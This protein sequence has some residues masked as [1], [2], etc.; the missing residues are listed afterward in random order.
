VTAATTDP[1]AS[2]LGRY[3]GPDIPLGYVL[4]DSHDGLA[5]IYD[6]PAG[7]LRLSYQE[8]AERSIRLAG[9][10]QQAGLAAGDRVAVMLPKSPELMTALLAIWRAGAVHVPL[11]T[12]FGPDA[13]A[14]R[15]GHSGAR[16][17]ITDSVNRDKF[18]GL[19]ASG[20]DV[21]CLPGAGTPL[22]RGDRDLAAAI[23]HG[24]PGT[25]LRR[26]G[27][28]LLILLYTSGT[29]GQPKG[30]ELPVRALASIHSYMHYGL[31]VRPDDVFWNIADP[32]WGYGLWFAIIGPLLLGQAT[33]LRNMPFDAADVASAIAR[34]RVTNLTGAPT[35]YRSLRAAGMP[36]GFRE[37]SR[38][39][40]VSSAGEPLN[41][42]LLD[43]SARELGVPLHDHYGQTELGMPAGFA[44]H[45]SLHRNP[46]PGSMGFAAPGYRVVLL[47]EDGREA[48]PGTAGEI[49]IDTQS[50]PLYWFRGY[51]RDPERTKDRFRHGPRYYLT[52]DK[53][54]W[55]NAGLLHF[56]SRTDDVIT[57]S[58]YRIGPFEVENALIAHPA[59]A[60]A[61]V[62]GIPDPLRGEAVTAV[63]VTAP[64]AAGTP[65]LAQELQLFVKSRL[66][67]HL[68]PRQVHFAGA[69]PRTPSGK[70]QRNILR[71][72]LSQ[73]T[74]Q[75]PA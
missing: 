38:L 21:F 7:T 52:G 34:H 39:R 28:D 63:V 59:V 75:V 73:Q 23:E 13:V 27:D 30:V 3:T 9:S 37:S 50:S 69:L 16:M 33:V 12:A 57:S 44:H 62:V 6:G 66:A 49:A 15:T 19:D 8:L 70:I 31:D 67:A 74:G 25:T 17:V 35:V 26:D 46:V 36:P 41:P 55:D 1:V 43:W 71:Q 56:A 53:A 2:W 61:A 51:H 65:E 18:T 47:S 5:L 4:C 22:H 72:Q 68:Y 29:T 48:G 20:V 58:G 64:G 32:G 40:H 14:Y 60:E 45:P 11:F 54:N 42:E 24:P 10:L